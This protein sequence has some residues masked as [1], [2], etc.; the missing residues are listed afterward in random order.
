MIFWLVCSPEKEHLQVL[1][2]FTVHCL[3]YAQ[4]FSWRYFKVFLWNSHFNWS[5]LKRLDF[6]LIFQY[7][8]KNPTRW[9]KI[10]IKTVTHKPAHPT[11]RSVPRRSLSSSYLGKTTLV[12]LGSMVLG[13]MKCPSGPFG[14]AGLAMCPPGILSTPAFL[15]WGQEKQKAPMQAAV[16]KPSSVPASQYKCRL[17]EIPNELVYNGVLC[18]QEGITCL[19][20]CIEKAV[21]EWLP[22]TA[23]RELQR[24]NFDWLQSM[25]FFV[26]EGSVILQN[27]SK[28]FHVCSIV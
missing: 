9:C 7:W 6:I 3:M 22:V 21:S 20:N 2:E 24:L 15:L 4:Y 14:S 8:G 19:E 12:L 17:G 16:E 13:G 10:T 23:S 5:I 28:A 25:C 18:L 27:K 11:S 1:P 26:L